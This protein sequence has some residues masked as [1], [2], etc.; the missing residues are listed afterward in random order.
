MQKAELVRWLRERE[1]RWEGLLAE[2]G[3]SR[4]EQPGVNGTWSMKDLVGHLTGWNVWLV[5]RLEAAL[6]GDEEPAP[7]WPAQLEA[8]DDI[9]AWIHTHYRERP[10]EAVLAEMREVHARLMA[11]VESLPDDVHIEHIEP[12]FY[13]PWVG[14]KRFHVAEFFDHFRDDHEADVRAWLARLR[15][16]KDGAD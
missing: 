13:L 2:V 5:A 14:K 6:R 9:N 3:P 15:G 1:A 12:A 16:E 10:L 8:E 11:A 7:P 4:M